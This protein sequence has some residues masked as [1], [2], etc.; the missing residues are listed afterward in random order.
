MPHFPLDQTLTDQ[1]NGK[2]SPCGPYRAH[3]LSDTGGLTQFGAFIEIL[4][5]GSASSIKHW[6]AHEDEMIHML[7]GETTLYEGDTTILMRPGD[8]A[9]FKAGSPQG[10]CLQNHSAAEARYLVIGTR[11]PS[12]V[13]TYPDQD[14]V[15]HFIRSPETRRWTDANGRPADSPYKTP[16]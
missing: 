10:H 6:H 2:G 15:Q 1:S 13:I 16:H 7:A 9:T 3:L 11:G 5:P 12:D 14:R 8:T 4:P